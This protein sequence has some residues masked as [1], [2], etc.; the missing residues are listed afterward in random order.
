MRLVVRSGHFAFYP[1]TAT[2]VARFCNYYGA[3]LVSV[4]DY[5]TFPALEDLKRYSIFGKPYGLLPATKTF[6]GQN[7]WDVMKANG[8]VYSLGVETLV[9]KES[10][11]VVVNPTLMNF[12]M[13]LSTALV[14][15][16]SR[17]TTGQQILSYAAEFVLGMHQLKV[18]EFKYE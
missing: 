5:F 9:S 18:T 3:T 1:R 17:D 7:P 13:D 16:G 4:E 10:I 8:F 12:Y 11:T 14:Q 15:P 6:E 2:D